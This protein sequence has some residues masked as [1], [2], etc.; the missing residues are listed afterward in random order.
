MVVNHHPGKGSLAL[1]YVQLES[2]FLLIRSPASSFP[3]G[4]VV[5]G[6]LPPTLQRL[7]FFWFRY[8]CAKSGVFQGGLSPS[9]VSV[10]PSG[11]GCAF[12]RA[13]LFSFVEFVW[14]MYWWLWKVIR[15]GK[16]GGRVVKRKWPRY[17]KGVSVRKGWPNPECVGGLGDMTTISRGFCVEAKQRFYG[18][19]VN[20]AWFVIAESE[21]R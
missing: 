6:S 1:D 19:I 18:I 10:F 21:S 7:W 4:T 17:C 20:R 13:P 5:P 3:L 12:F 16:D 8:F 14:G 9:L 11:R 2:L 15:K